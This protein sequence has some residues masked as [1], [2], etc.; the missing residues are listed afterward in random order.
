MLPAPPPG[1]VA[2][3]TADQRAHL[4]HELRALHVAPPMRRAAWIGVLNALAPGLGTYQIMGWQYGLTEA[5]LKTVLALDAIAFTATTLAATPGLPGQPSQLLPGLAAVGAV[6]AVSATAT[7]AV[8]YAWESTLAYHLQDRVRDTISLLRADLTPL[9]PAR[10][11]HGLR[12]LAAARRQI[13]A[14]ELDDA[15]ES[16]RQLLEDDPQ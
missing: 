2:D 8:I 16:L 7:G 6:Q 9:T 14:G 15:N 12:Q 10:Y 13:A 3:V 4:I 11:E 1:L 5:H